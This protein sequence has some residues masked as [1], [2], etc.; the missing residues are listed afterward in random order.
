MKHW[1][2]FIA[3]EL[4]PNS[5][6]N[7]TLTYFSGS[8]DLQ[9]PTLKPWHNTHSHFHDWNTSKSAPIF[10][11]L[12]GM[13]LWNGTFLKSKFKYRLGWS[14]INLYPKL[15][16]YPKSITPFCCVPPGAV[17]NRLQQQSP[18]SSGWIQPMKTLA[19]DWKTGWERA[20]GIH[21]PSSQVKTSN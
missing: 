20:W 16:F 2:L 5:P 3:M 8:P 12:R 1:R 14:H 4:N 15:S 13:S 6:H 11:T 10:L 21:S 18:L 9:P 7:P 19:E 17:L